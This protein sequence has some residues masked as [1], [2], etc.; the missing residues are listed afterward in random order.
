LP[1][2]PAITAATILAASLAAIAVRRADAVD[3]TR[4]AAAATTA[5]R[6]AADVDLLPGRFVPNVQPDGNTVV[7]RGSEGLVV[8]DT[9]RH[10]EHTQA[11]LDH[12]K[13]AGLP[14]AAVVNTHWHLDHVG[15]NPVVRRVYPGVRVFASGAIQ[16]ALVGFLADYR[17]QL[18]AMVDK[19]PDPEAHKPWRAEI[20]LIDAGPALGPD[21][22]I[23][24]TAERTL[25][26]R[27]LRLGYVARAV[28]A[29]DVWVFDPATRVLAAG[30]LVTLP[31]PFL[32]TACPAGWQ[33]A[34]DALAETDFTTLVPGHGPPMTPQDFRTYK[35]AFGGL[36]ACAASDRVKN[37]CIDGW[38]KD[39]A[40]LLKDEDPG[41]VRPLVDYYVGLLR[42]DPARI[43]RLCAG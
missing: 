24:G 40:A 29:G 30:D 25:A 41:F 18:E 23:D 1:S 36:L 39:A 7:F 20:G 4:P 12:A 32:D 11:I 17:A 14:I 26:G 15:G 35:T 9:G 28:T 22:V 33:K 43:A 8:V 10:A 13:T 38:T 37:D 6:I 21:V 16:G 19:T 42:G 31:A 3:A 27:P 34:L 5:T 2:R